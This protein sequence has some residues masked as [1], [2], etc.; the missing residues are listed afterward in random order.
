MVTQNL[1]SEKFTRFV[2]GVVLGIECRFSVSEWIFQMNVWVSAHGYF[3]IAVYNKYENFDMKKKNELK[4][5]LSIVCTK[6]DVS[7]SCNKQ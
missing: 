6:I 7:D 5:V 1:E 2:M 3:Y 4:I